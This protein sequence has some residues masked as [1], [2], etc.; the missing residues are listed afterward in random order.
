[1]SRPSLT[2][3][4]IY[5]PPPG[6]HVT[7]H[8]LRGQDACAVSAVTVQVEPVDLSVRTPHG[9]THTDPHPP[10]PLLG[11][12]TLSAFLQRVSGSHVAEARV[13]SQHGD[14]LQLSRRE[15]E[16]SRSKKMHGCPHPGC[17]KVSNVSCHKSPGINSSCN[18]FTF[19]FQELEVP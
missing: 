10:P 4:P 8:D 2:I 15:R 16:W 14:G 11:G 17:D 13:L 7:S 19:F 3:T 1:M 6:H 12:L 5:G 18:L 9:D